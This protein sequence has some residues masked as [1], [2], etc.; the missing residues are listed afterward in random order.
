MGAE[1]RLFVGIG[2]QGNG[3]A[4]GEHPTGKKFPGVGDPSRL[5][6]ERD[7]A[8]AITGSAQAVPPLGNR[9]IIGIAPRL[10]AQQIAVALR[11]FGRGRDMQTIENRIAFFDGSD[12]EI[13]RRR[14]DRLFRQLLPL[15][16]GEAGAKLP[17]LQLG[18]IFLLNNSQRR[19]PFRFV[20]GDR[21]LIGQKQQHA[22]LRNRTANID[23]TALRL[24]LFLARQ[25][26][27]LLDRV[28][29]AG[30]LRAGDRRDGDR[31]KRQRG[32]HHTDHRIRTSAVGLGPDA[33]RACFIR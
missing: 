20:S 18:G 30:R 17:I 31:H 11:A 28:G 26:V 27:P 8:H 32:R 23:I 4:K 9:A 5:H 33:T 2:L 3:Q 1:V 14:L 7:R 24:D 21:R 19:R 12:R 16:V 15:A 29:I 10:H 22:A 25:Q 6:L 13:L